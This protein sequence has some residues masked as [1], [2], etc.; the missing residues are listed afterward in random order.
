MSSKLWSEKESSMLRLFELRC[1]IFTGEAKEWWGWRSTLEG[2]TSITFSKSSLL[3]ASLGG[4]SVE[5]VTESIW[6]SVVML[7]VVFRCGLLLLNLRWKK[8]P[9]LLPVLLDLLA[10][11]D[12]CWQRNEIYW[13]LIQIEKLCSG[14]EMLSKNRNMHF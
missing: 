4:P 11:K 3:L 7:G 1:R 12:L 5:G 10:L 6:I 2:S 9:P 13:Y 14:L 8:E